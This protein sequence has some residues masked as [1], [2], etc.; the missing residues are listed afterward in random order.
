MQWIKFER[1]KNA[2]QDSISKIGEFVNFSVSRISAVNSELLKQS[3]VFCMAPWIQLHAQTTGKISPCCMSTIYD[4]NELG[5]LRENPGIEAAWNSENMKQ[6]RKKMLEGKKSTI[7][8]HCYDYERLGKFS[9]RMT[10]NRDFRHYFSRVK[11]TLPD[12]S[13]E[14]ADVPLLDIRFSNKCNYKCRICDSVYSSLW[15]EEELK[16]G[17]TPGLPS[18]KEMKAA[19][20]EPVFWQ[21]FNRL[22][23]GVKR[24]HFAGGEPLVMDEHYKT[25]EYLIASGRNDVTLSYNTNFSTLKYKEHSLPD[26][27]NQF[28]RV[29]AWASLDDMGE[30]GNYHRK[31]QRWDKIEE[32]IRL[33]QEHCR[34]VR[35]GVNATVSIFNALYIPEFVEYMVK[36]KFVQ[37][38][39]LNLYL[40][41]DPPYFNITH[42]TPSLKNE[43]NERYLH[44]EQ[45]F[46]SGIKNDSHLR[47]H[48]HA[49]L[50]F[51]NSEQGS[52]Q[53]EFRHWVKAVDVVRNE[54]F[55]EVFPEL[56]EMMHEHQNPVS[57]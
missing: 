38:R 42:L 17:K 31:G 52:R 54:K 49:V 12:G 21:S 18:T 1:M 16:I 41:F 27:W 5:D 19:F 4:G 23:N 25:L 51:M 40:L 22:L 11:R 53:D 14:D 6:L 20:D 50:K 33:V 28:K 30:R 48:L 35:L 57:R 9:E 24:V 45:T 34:T 26:L 43:V 29:D 13:I 47:N 44:F 36:K 46:L 55:E 7:C 32:N 15:Y 56:S 3:E 2:L 10:Y 8:N 37:P 39:M